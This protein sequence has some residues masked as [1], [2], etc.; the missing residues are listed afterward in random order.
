[1]EPDAIRITLESRIRQQLTWDIFVQQIDEI[2]QLSKSEQENARSALQ[3]L[4]IAFGNSFPYLA[5]K[6][7]HPL[8]DYLIGITTPW[9]CRWL[10]WL[11]SAFAGLKELD[12]FKELWRR[13][14]AIDQINKAIEGL[15]VIEVAYKFFKAG[16]RV[17]FEPSVTVS[18]KRHGKQ[19]IG[20]KKPDLKLLN[21]ETN[22]EVY[23]EVTA[24]GISESHRLI[25]YT[26]DRISGLL[27][28]L[29]SHGLVIYARIHKALS[30]QGLTD[31]E[32]R[33][34]HL[35]ETVRT[36][37]EGCILEIPNTIE[38][39]IALEKDTDCVHQWAAA[40]DIGP[41]VTGA[42][43][44]QLELPRTRKRVYR[45]AQQLPASRPGIIVIH[46]YNPLFQIYSIEEI[47][48]EIERE[49]RKYPQLLCAIISHRYLSPS[50]ANDS[51][52]KKGPH[53]AVRMKIIDP[54]WENTTILFN[55]SYKMTISNST[56]ERLH[57]SFVQH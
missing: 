47:V 11:A 27:F 19:S 57:N 7:H 34:R 53:L 22:E 32:T 16:F 5:W 35:I 17:S 45:K 29:L 39:G 42:M 48:S 26:Y 46:Q 43:I 25:S 41:G 40:K 33:I 38:V 44:P 31:V 18:R 12:G 49:V 8:S 15:S 55:G 21:E 52:E 1:M 10:M 50:E 13:I 2:D 28:P 37:N 4:R 36:T 56:L 24:L 30:E 3:T 54:L 23:I 9:R 14:Q 20:P 51:M 6:S